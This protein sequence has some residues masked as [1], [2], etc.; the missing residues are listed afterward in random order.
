[1]IEWSLNTF[2][3]GKLYPVVAYAHDR[4]GGAL[5]SRIGMFTGDR[6]VGFLFGGIIGRDGMTE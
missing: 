4:L 3:L 5:Q 2:F 6:L 1:M